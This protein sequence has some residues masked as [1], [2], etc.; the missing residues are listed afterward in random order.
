M[1]QEN[2]AVVRGIVEALGA[3]DLEAAL[4]HMHPDVEFHEDP[5]FP[6][7]GVYRGRA[8]IAGYARQFQDAWADFDYELCDTFEAGNR[9]V[10]VLHIRGQ[11]MSS[12]ARFD[13]EGGWVW[14][15]RD[16]QAVRCDAYLHLDEAL[17][18]VGLRD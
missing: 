9:V 13:L 16:G 11:G 3:G 4:G 18:A 17:E 7:S 5:H 10:A 14:T 8:A 15:I 12:G 1:S 6:E 2:V